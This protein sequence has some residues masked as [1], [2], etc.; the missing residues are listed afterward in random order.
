MAIEYIHDASGA[1]I[2][3]T[4]KAYGEDEV[5]DVVRVEEQNIFKQV[6]ASQ[7]DS[8]LGSTGAIGDYLE[9]LII[10]VETPATA[11]VTIK[12]GNGSARTMFPNSP[13]GGIGTYVVPVGA[14]SEAGGWSVTTLAGSTVHCIGRFT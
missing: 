14:L 6:A 2:H 7:T 1:A 10:V 11:K 5:N 13:G 12:D 9:K 3:R 8:M 4:D